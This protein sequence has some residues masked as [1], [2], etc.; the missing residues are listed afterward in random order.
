[1][2]IQIHVSTEEEKQELLAASEHIHYLRELDTD[3][4]GCNFIA[5]LYLAPELIVVDR[6]NKEKC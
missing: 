6:T 5:H 1:M 4:P 3:M 2:S